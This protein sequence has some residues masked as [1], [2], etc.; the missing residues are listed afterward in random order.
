MDLP[1][2]HKLAAKRPSGRDSSPLD[3]DDG[4]VIRYHFRRALGVQ[5]V[6]VNARLKAD[7]L[8]LVGR[9]PQI[10]RNL[11]TGDRAR[12]ASHASW[13]M[14]SDGRHP[15][16]SQNSGPGA[17]QEWFSYRLGR[18]HYVSAF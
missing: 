11:A 15:W 5:M 1:R 3:N 4:A 10:A 13:N 14:D 16:F 2:L 18:R 17:Y 8:H 7:R 12:Q 6:T 9:T